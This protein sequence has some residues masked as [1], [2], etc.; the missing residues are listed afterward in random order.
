MPVHPA[1]IRSAAVVAIA[2]TFAVVHVTFAVACPEEHTAAA[3]DVETTGSLGE[4]VLAENCYFELVSEETPD[5][6]TVTQRVHECD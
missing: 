4:I 3:L 5:G 1:L 6:R 2:S